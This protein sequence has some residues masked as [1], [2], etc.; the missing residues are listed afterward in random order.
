M[1]LQ[2]NSI[3]KKIGFTLLLI[4]IF[5]MGHPFYLSVCDLKYNASTQK[6]EGT[7]KVFVTDLED[8][9]NRLENKNVDL[10]HPNNKNETL[11]LLNTYLKNRLKLQGDNK[12]L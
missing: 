11:V 3:M 7:V 1:Q 5:S 8:A 10:I 4:I 2:I 9:L 12:P 6:L